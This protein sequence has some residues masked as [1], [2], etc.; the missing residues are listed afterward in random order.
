M[1]SS[2]G[3][4]TASMLPGG[5]NGK[6]Y[7]FNSAKGGSTTEVYVPDGAPGADPVSPG[8]AE[9]SSLATEHPAQLEN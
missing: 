3:A 9:G 6:L 7:Q 2:L 5:T 1:E 8:V 4:W